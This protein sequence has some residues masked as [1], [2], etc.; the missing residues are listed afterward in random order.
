MEAY[1][2]EEFLNIRARVS[3]SL[4]MLGYTWEHPRVQAFLAR[5]AA[6]EGRKVASKHDLPFWAYKQLAAKLSEE[7]GRQGYV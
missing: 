4:E 2:I 1:G 3:V 7:L 5:V 6:R